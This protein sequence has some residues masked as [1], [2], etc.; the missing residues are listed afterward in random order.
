VNS[1]RPMDHLMARDVSE[2]DLL[3]LKLVSDISERLLKAYDESES[4]E[5]LGKILLPEDASQLQKN[6]LGRIVRLSL[7]KLKHL[8][9]CKYDD[10]F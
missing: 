4:D 1:P 2:T 9:I 3:E 10:S 5:A 7:D 8:T 6:R